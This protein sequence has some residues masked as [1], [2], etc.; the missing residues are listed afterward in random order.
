MIRGRDAL[1]TRGRDVRATWD[2]LDTIPGD[3]DSR[4]EFADQL[5]GGEGFFDF[6][7]S[8]VDAGEV[9]EAAVTAFEDKAVAHGR[10]DGDQQ[11][12]AVD[13][14]RLAGQGLNGHAAFKTGMQLLVGAGVSHDGQPLPLRQREPVAHELQRTFVRV[15]LGQQHGE[16]GQGL[17]QARN[18]LGR[19]QLRVGGVWS[20]M[21]SLVRQFAIYELRITNYDWR[22]REVRQPVRP[23][24]KS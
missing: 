24:D 22:R 17:A 4:Q 12:V 5:D 6:A 20:S 16:V 15:A 19:E 1:G 18:L 9:A 10:L 14:E 2:A 13:G 8:A 11:I 21:G 3:A 7:I 23:S